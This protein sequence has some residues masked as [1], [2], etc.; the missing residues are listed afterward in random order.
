M[1]SGTSYVS[2]K[3]KQGTNKAREFVGEQ[4]IKRERKRYE[5]KNKKKLMLRLSHLMMRILQKT[6]KET[7]QGKQKG[8]GLTTKAAVVGGATA[9]GY[10][11]GSSN[12][13]ILLMM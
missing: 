5:R 7:R 12:K 3:M 8:M 4:K 11:A 1:K 13:K 2:S 10:A 6:A 9:A